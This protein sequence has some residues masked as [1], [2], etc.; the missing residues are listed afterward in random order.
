MTDQFAAHLLWMD[1]AP[2]LP[3]RPYLMRLGTAT[4]TAT[5]QR[6]RS[7]SSTSAPACAD[8][9]QAARD[10]TRSASCNLALDRAIAF[11]TY[12]ENRETGSFIL[13]DRISNATV[14]AGMIRFRA[15][16]R[17]QPPLA[18]IRPSTR[19]HARRSRGISP[20]VLWFTGLSG[21]GKS[22]IANVRREAAAGA[23]PAH[24]HCWTATTSATA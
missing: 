9:G 3:G 15:A 10:R 16:P 1:E 6:A 22:T 13:I 12:G 18:A 8:G 19:P 2:M 4:L 14:G 11:D 24:L 7:I 21:S 23:R 17:R 5:V 20:A